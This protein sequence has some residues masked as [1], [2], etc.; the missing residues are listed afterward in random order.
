MYL[1]SEQFI[2]LCLFLEYVLFTI[3]NANNDVRLGERKISS[4]SK[5]AALNI[6]LDKNIL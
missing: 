6:R 2:L 4:E 3:F 5:S 1:L